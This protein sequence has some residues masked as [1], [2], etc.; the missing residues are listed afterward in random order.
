ML[1]FQGLQAFLASDSDLCLFKV[2][3]LVAL[4]KFQHG[5][6]TFFMPRTIGDVSV[7][8]PARIGSCAFVIAAVGKPVIYGSF[9]GYFKYPDTD[10]YVHRTVTIFSF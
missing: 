8:T 9:K 4:V 6:E 5:A 1:Y 3:I 7:L 2:R 10:L